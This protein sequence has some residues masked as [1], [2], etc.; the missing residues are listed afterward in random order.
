MPKLKTVIFNEIRKYHTKS[1]NF[2]DE[3]LNQVIFYNKDGIRLTFSGY[4]L[5]SKIFTAYRFDIKTELKS[6]HYIGLSTLEFPY[7]ITDARLILFSEVDAA[8][9][10]LHGGV[11]RFLESCFDIDHSTE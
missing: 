4:L 3:Q 5:I 2:T 10:K 8:V 11:E 6:K 1:A 9:I 7:Y